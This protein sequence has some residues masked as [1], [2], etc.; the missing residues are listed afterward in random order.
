MPRIS[1]ALWA[2]TTSRQS[3]RATQWMISHYRMISAIPR[4]LSVSLLSLRRLFP[5]TSQVRR[6]PPVAPCV[7]SFRQQH[8]HEHNHQPHAHLQVVQNLCVAAPAPATSLPQPQPQ[9]QIPNVLVRGTRSVA[10]AAF[11]DILARV[12]RGGRAIPPQLLFPAGIASD[13]WRLVTPTPTGHWRQAP[14]GCRYQATPSST[15]HSHLTV[16][17][18]LNPT[19]ALT[20]T[21]TF[22]C[23]FLSLLSLLEASRS[24]W[25]TLLLTFSPF[26]THL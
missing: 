26:Q 21:L 9:P 10:E 2:T 18:S 19:L 20:L 17:P 6:L 7:A 4:A 25:K 16:T 14:A 24:R 11:R 15:L 12:V 1:P 22:R 23:L 5:I 8:K 13:R 3:T